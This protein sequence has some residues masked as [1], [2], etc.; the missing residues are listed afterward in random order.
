MNMEAVL[1]TTFARAMF[2]D[3]YL[4]SPVPLVMTPKSPGLCKQNQPDFRFTTRQWDE[5]SS[6]TCRTDMRR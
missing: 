2:D 4:N 6:R 1:Q 5:L 3:A